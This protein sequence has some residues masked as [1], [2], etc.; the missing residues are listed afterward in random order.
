MAA[1]HLLDATA[2]LNEG[3]K[4]AHQGHSMFGGK[5]DLAYL[6]RSKRQEK[7]GQ[8]RWHLMHLSTQVLAIALV[9]YLIL[10]DDQDQRCMYQN[11]WVFIW[12]L[13]NSMAMNAQLLLTVG[14]GFYYATT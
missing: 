10:V 2:E 4:S 8:E 13:F 14:F 7:P 11:P 12:V 6:A 3:Y 1:Y 5:P 9:C